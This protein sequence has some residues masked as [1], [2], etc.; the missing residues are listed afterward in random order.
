MRIC[1]GGLDDGR[2]LDLLRLHLAG[3]HENSPPE[4]VFALDLSGLGAEDV[5]FFTVWRGDTLLG[6]GALRELD[7]AT[8]EIKSMRTHPAHLGKG[9]ANR[10]LDHLLGLA[11]ARGYRRVSLETGHGPAFEP[12]LSLYRRNGF[13]EGPPFAGYRP[14]V[15]SR[16]FHLDL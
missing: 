12:A 14:N 15:F 13:T 2:V 10:L 3:M 5:A 7:A 4:N 11:R 1:E 9:V 8:G 16:F 6:M